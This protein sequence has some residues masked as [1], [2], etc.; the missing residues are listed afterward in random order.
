MR[1]RILSA[2]MIDPEID[3]LAA[4]R[5]LNNRYEG[6]KRLMGE[7]CSDVQLK[8]YDRSVKQA[9]REINRLRDLVRQAR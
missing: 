5:I 4:D 8:I 6:E 3:I 1:S 7:V 9:D 2:L